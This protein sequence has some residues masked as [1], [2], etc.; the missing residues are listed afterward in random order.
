VC[1]KEPEN[2][3]QLLKSSPRKQANS[4]NHHQQK[5]WVCFF[6]KQFIPFLCWCCLAGNHRRG[7]RCSSRASLAPVPSPVGRGLG[8]PDAA[9]GSGSRHLCPGRC[10]LFLLPESECLPVSDHIK[11]VI[12]SSGGS[13]HF[14]IDECDQQTVQSVLII[15][16]LLG[17]G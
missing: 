13:L 11:G 1:N 6:Y 9:G 17:T 7:Q 5:I 12:N 14:R 10:C 2:V 15:K 16:T 3:L 4:Q 8:V